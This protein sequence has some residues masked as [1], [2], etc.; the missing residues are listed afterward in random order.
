M[1]L[2]AGNGYRPKIL[3]F[4]SD[5]ISDPA[6]EGIKEEIDL[7]RDGTIKVNPETLQTSV[8]NVFAGGD[9]VTGPSSII[10][11][12]GQGKKAVWY[13]DRFLEGLDMNAEHESKL[14]AIDVKEV[15][16]RPGITNSTPRIN[17]KIRTPE[18]RVADLEEIETTFT[19]EEARKS[20]ERCLDCASCRECHMCIEACP[21]DCIDF[22]QKEKVLDVSAKS[23]V[24][25][26]GFNLFPLE[27]LPNYGAGKFKNVISAM[28]MERHLVPTR[29]YNT[30]LRPKDGCVPDNIA[31]VLCAGSRDHS[32]NNTICSP[33]CCMY[34]IKQG[35]LLMGALPVADITIYYIDIRSFGKDFEEFYQGDT[36]G[37]AIVER[38]YEE[39]RKRDNITL[40]TGAELIASQGSVGNFDLTIKINPRYVK[41]KCTEREFEKMEKACPISVPDEFNFGL[42]ER[43]AIYK[44]GEKALPPQAAI[45]MEACNK[46]GEC[47]KICK[48]NIILGQKPE[49]IK[50]KVGAILTNTGFDP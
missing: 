13:I 23:V 10:E 21:A 25:A 5:K 40:L 45:D 42:K 19:E 18:E 50:L 20:A 16:K 27:K 28:E 11:A 31:Y 43:K 32:V 38:L 46:C 37:D 3:V 6:T 44:R 35:Q 14:P 24:I 30:V 29:P 33:I 8:Q 15:L 12:I 1:N 41:G 36:R 4:S 9:V 7:N 39:V 34:S 48:E 47:E 22:F 17:G 2:S 49:S 26:T